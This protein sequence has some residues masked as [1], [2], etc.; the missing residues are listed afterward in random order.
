MHTRVLTARCGIGRSVR[1]AIAAASALGVGYGGVASAQDTRTVY[2]AT[3]FNAEAGPRPTAA[4]L[5]LTEREYPS[6]AWWENADGHNSGPDRAFKSV[7]AAIKQKDRA[8]LLKLTDPAQ[9]GDTARFD[10][11]A[12]AFFQQFQS[13]QLLDV[14]RAYEFDGMVVFFGKFQSARQ[15]VFVPL[16][17]AREGDDSFG[18]LPARTDIH[19]L[20]FTVVS[21]WFAPSGAAADAPT[22]CTDSDV[23]RATHRV[24]ARAVGVAA[25]LA[26]AHRR[27]ARRAG[28]G[29][30][31]RGAGEVRHRP[32]AIG[33]SRR[34]RGRLSDA[35]DDRGR[36]SIARLVHE[37]RTKKTATATSPRSSTNSRSSC[38]T[39]RRSWSRTPGRGAATFMRCISR[40]RPTSGCSGRTLPTSP[41]RIRSS[42]Q[43]PLVAAAAS[44][45]PFSDLVIKK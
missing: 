1:I 3:T 6:T 4:C 7:I 12:S 41:C 29:V 32:D 8:A 39:S 40:S 28:T 37:R 19:T 38:S 43:G 10:Q 35:P 34:G 13:I 11:Q 17:F 23:K 44:K 42:K 24:V 9:A 16:A 18:F 20:T 26:L 30:P 27:A 15:T 25:K 2:A 31:D 33:L 5:Q 21:D 45:Q 36:G 22:Y 14:P